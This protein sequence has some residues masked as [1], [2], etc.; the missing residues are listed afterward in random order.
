M[1]VSAHR[2]AKAYRSASQNS[3]AHARKNFY[4]PRGYEPVS[5][6]FPKEKSFKE[7]LKRELERTPYR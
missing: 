6:A 1:N 7:L 4:L 3:E 5:E 2:I